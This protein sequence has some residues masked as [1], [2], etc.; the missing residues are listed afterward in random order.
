[1][2]NKQFLQNKLSLSSRNFALVD[3]EYIGSSTD[4]ENYAKGSIMN[5]LNASRNVVARTRA[6]GFIF[7]LR[8]VIGGRATEHPFARENSRPDWEYSLKI[9]G[10]GGESQKMQVQGNHEDKP[11]L[12]ES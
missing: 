8:H 2:L 6:G 3:G 7:L 5:V 4:D 10:A 12:Y 11:K 1:L 9:G